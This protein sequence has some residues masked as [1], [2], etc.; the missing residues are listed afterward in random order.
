[1]PLS[2][3]VSKKMSSSYQQRLQIVEELLNELFPEVAIPL[4]H[5]D[6]YTLLIAVLLSAQCTDERVNKVTPALFAKAASAE[7]M[8]LLSIEEIRQLIAPCGLAPTKA[9]HIHL[10]S[11]QLRDQHN[12]LVPASFE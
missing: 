2:V 1:S 4:N 5:S 7:A 11:K 10:L 12:G 6:P 3:W 9:R 8:A